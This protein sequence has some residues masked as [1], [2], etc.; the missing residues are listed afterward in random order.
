M[1]PNQYNAEKRRKELEKKRKKE[2][3]AQRRAEHK[4]HPDGE[5]PEGEVPEG[6]VD[7]QDAAEA[8]ENSL[9]AAPE[10][11]KSGED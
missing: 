11:E 9:D 5:L 2:E 4:K 1:R 10:G 6:E 3:K 8:A 7:G